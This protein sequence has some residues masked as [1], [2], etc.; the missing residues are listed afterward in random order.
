MQNLTPAA[1]E[2]YVIYPSKPFDM[3]PEKPEILIQNVYELINQSCGS[4]LGELILSDLTMGVSDLI[5][6]SQNKEELCRT[7]ILDKQQKGLPYLSECQ[8]KSSGIVQSISSDEIL[9]TLSN[10]PA[11][12][13]DCFQPN[14]S[15]YYPGAA[16]SCQRIV[17]SD[18]DCSYSTTMFPAGSDLNG[19]PSAQAVFTLGSFTQGSHNFDDQY[20]IHMRSIDSPYPLAY[21][22]PTMESTF[23][24]LV[25]YASPCSNTFD[26]R[27]FHW[28]RG[29]GS[30]PESKIKASINVES[31]IANKRTV[32]NGYSIYYSGSNSFHPM[33]HQKLAEWI[34]T[35]P[36]GSNNYTPNIQYSTNSSGKQ[37][38]YDANYF[39]DVMW[40]D[41]Q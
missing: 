13:L 8:K 39:K 32:P 14:S 11:S 31:I 18:K 19:M 22:V 7:A 36:M 6:G 37:I 17:P 21:M 10:G 4:G 27:A 15:N 1:E 2:N 28:K 25:K 23:S 35:V 5:S 33:T 38:E 9:N 26:I 16:W 20:F 24:Y 3:L 41:P 29:S 34:L 12:G 30:I 40:V